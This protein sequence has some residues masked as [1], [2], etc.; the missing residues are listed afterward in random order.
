ML[1]LFASIFSINNAFGAKWLGANPGDSTRYLIDIVADPLPRTL[2]SFGLRYLPSDSEK[3]MTIE[4]NA[5]PIMGLFLPRMINVDIETG[6]IMDKN[7]PHK[8]WLYWVPADKE[9]GD[10]IQLDFGEVYN[11]SNVELTVKEFGVRSFQNQN[12]EVYIAEGESDGK[13]V[14]YVVEKSRGVVLEALV[15]DSSRVLFDGKLVETNVKMKEA[16]KVSIEA[17][18]VQ[19]PAPAEEEEKTSTN[20]SVAMKEKKKLTLVSIKNQDDVPVYAVK[21]K[22]TDG[23]IKFIKVRDW[24]RERVDQNTV[25]VQTTDRPLA[26]GTLILMLIVDKKGSGVEW[27]A[28]DKMGIQIASGSLTSQ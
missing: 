15:K 2:E 7:V 25:I 8:S 12:I 28:I 9:V 17:P 18:P 4:V 5:G 6:E 16:S 11:L 14:S 22:T 3:T 23:N 27:S 26:K 19:V 10:T 24:E 1:I 20:I 13:T 21:I